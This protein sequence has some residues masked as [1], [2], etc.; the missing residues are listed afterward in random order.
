MP[1][2]F[3]FFSKRDSSGVLRKS[4]RSSSSQP[5]PRTPTSPPHASTIP[6]PSIADTSEQLESSELSLEAEYVLADAEL[7]PVTSNAIYPLSS[8]SNAASTSTTKLKMP[9]RR[10][11]T[12][13]SKLTNIPSHPPTLPPKGP[14]KSS[15]ESSVSHSPSLLPPPSRS[16][17][18]GSYADP[19]SASSTRSLPQGV[20]AIHSRR[21]SRDVPQ[22]MYETMSDPDSH[23]I[24][25]PQYK[26]PSKGGLFSW[27]R[28]RART[29]SKPSQ[30]DSSLSSAPV[31][32][33]PPPDSFNLK[34]FR[35]VTIPT[36]ESPSSGSPSDRDPQPRPRPRGG[37]QAS[38]DAA[39]RI[40]VAAFREA[41]ARRSATNSPVPSLPGDRDSFPPGQV[42]T[43]R[44]SALATPPSTTS[45]GSQPRAPL[46]SSSQ[47]R[48]P[49]ARSSIAPLSFSSSM[50][51]S[52]SSEE[53]ESE[54]EEEAT[55]RPR[56]RRTITSRSAQSENGFRSSPVLSYAASRSDVGHGPT[57]SILTR[58]SP[59]PRNNVNNSPKPDGSG[60]RSRT[61]SVYSRTRVSLS[62]S[63]L[64]PA[65]ATKRAPA[66]SRNTVA[67]S[68]PTHPPPRSRSRASTSSEYSSKSS[69]SEDLPLASL[70]RPAS[71]MS[72]GSGPSR[73]PAKP[74]VDI[75]QLVGEYSV[76]PP[77]ASE[78]SNP[79]QLA[80]EPDSPSTRY[81]KTSLGLGER[82]S[83]LASGLG[84]LQP[85]RSKSPDS[86]SDSRDEAFTPPEIPEKLRPSPPPIISPPISNTKPASPALRSKINKSSSRSFPTPKL[87]T[88]SLNRDPVISPP[89]SSSTSS[90][91]PIPHITPTPIRERQ[92]PPAF[93]VTS[94]PTS[95][96][97]N[98]SIG[99]L[100]GLDQAIADMD[101]NPV[102]RRSVA[103]M[104]GH[105]K[106]D[107]Q[108][109]R[110]P[111]QEDSQTT[112]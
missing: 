85:S 105:P 26:Q 51:S 5:S 50:T 93:A 103:A 94:R 39:Q 97:S 13:S 9:F 102:P 49:P 34:S 86:T 31:L 64:V 60:N 55:L 38:D 98:P 62:T 46:P 42:R 106:G 27:A 10:K 90:D 71:A 44:R 72:R 47:I 108:Q 41:Q 15:A 22:Q 59:T 80:A 99:T 53:E 14:R 29:K 54:S 66:V 91:A 82:L 6:S 24:F 63:A 2:F 36:P 96:A 109:Q 52:E 83:A 8:S 107:Q 56:R 65:A 79:L 101:D 95:H 81:R 92:E 28:P 4:P 76:I 20:P 40:S 70:Q 3:A 48:S 68:R 88:L 58:P 78:P 77:C 25:A 16:A 61:S 104:E 43:R 75:G 37:S 21:S 19:H 110:R 32:T 67:V 12:A 69:S 11:Q 30:P 35:H 1:A 87:D 84:G 17:I 89:S 7:S 18:F 73:R 33:L 45:A 112:P 100:A 57:P 23:T 74:L 111:P